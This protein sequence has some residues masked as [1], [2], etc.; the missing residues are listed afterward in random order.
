MPKTL[1]HAERGD[2]RGVGYWRALAEH[3]HRHHHRADAKRRGGAPE[4]HSRDNQRG[5]VWTVVY[6]WL[7]FSN[8][9]CLFFLQ[10]EA[11]QHHFA[12]GF[13]LKKIPPGRLESSTM[14]EPQRSAAWPE[15]LALQPLSGSATIYVD[16][17]SLYS[18]S[19]EWRRSLWGKFH[20]SGKRIISSFIFQIMGLQIVMLLKEFNGFINC[21]EVH[22][23]HRGRN[24]FLIPLQSCI[25]NIWGINEYNLWYWKQNQ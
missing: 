6:P 17:L 24:D 5:A 4:P 15:A 9:L 22:C 7:G 18:T 1:Q 14:T 23:R 13:F 21:T 20:R 12:M 16:M 3:H 25:A 8:F 19:T 2:G 11:K 10:L